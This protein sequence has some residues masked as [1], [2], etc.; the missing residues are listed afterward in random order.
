MKQGKETALVRD[1]LQY[2]QA[3]GIMAWRKSVECNYVSDKMNT[4]E[5]KG[6]ESLRLSIPSNHN[7]L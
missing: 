6:T 5:S 1:C 7:Q 3:K 4:T 2:L